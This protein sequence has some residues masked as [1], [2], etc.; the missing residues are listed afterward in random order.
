MQKRIELLIDELSKEISISPE[1]IENIFMMQW[2]FVKEEMQNGKFKTIKLQSWGKYIPSE[3]KK[4]R[5]ENGRKT[6]KN[7]Q[8]RTIQGAE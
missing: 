8:D 2:K 5:I 6:T 3:K 7:N 4:Q 1:I